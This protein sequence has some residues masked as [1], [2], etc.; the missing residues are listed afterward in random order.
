MQINSIWLQ[1]LAP[2]GVSE[3][4]LRDN[5]CVNVAIGTWILANHLS[6]YPP[7]TAIGNYHSKTSHLN[8]GYQQR[9]YKQMLK[10]KNVQMVIDR[11]NSRLQKVGMR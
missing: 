7:W 1:S 11:A 5:G 10:V 4:V 9:V 3:S 6:Q 2:Y 8:Q